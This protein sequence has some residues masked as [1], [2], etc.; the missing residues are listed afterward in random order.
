VDHEPLV[1]PSA[2]KREADGIT[3][4]ELLHAYAHQLGHL[5]DERHP[6]GPMVLYVGPSRSGAMLLEVGVP[7]RPWYGMA[8]IVHGMRARPLILRGMGLK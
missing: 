4:E 5:V 8:V 7:V 3:E 2:L 1:L 6:D